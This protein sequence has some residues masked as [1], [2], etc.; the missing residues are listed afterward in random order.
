MCRNLGK[1]KK[2]GGGETSNFRENRKRERES[3]ASLL[4]RQR[5]KKKQA[6][7]PRTH[8]HTLYER[9]G[10]RERDCT[11]KKV[12][13]D[14]YTPA[15]ALYTVGVPRSQDQTTHFGRGR[16]EESGLCHPS[17]CLLLLF[18]KGRLVMQKRREREERA[19]F[20]AGEERTHRFRK[21]KSSP[22]KKRDTES[23]CTR[24][25]RVRVRLE[26][27]ERGGMVGI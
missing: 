3:C 4:V 16:G 5:G 10:G 26:S 24:T 19:L 20:W 9:R 22:Q 12:V 15:V 2:G 8:T 14:S 27:W 13:E 6:A 21:E 18:L 25:V 11:I 1:K 7:K 23:I 17:E